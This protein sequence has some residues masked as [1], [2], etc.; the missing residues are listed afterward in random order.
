MLLSFIWTKLTC[1]RRLRSASVSVR[2]FQKARMRTIVRLSTLVGVKYHFPMKKN[3]YTGGGGV[4][5]LDINSIRFTVDSKSGSQSYL[6]HSSR[7]FRKST[8]VS[9]ES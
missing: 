4:R 3:N 8:E 1:G 5:T 6:T 9:P 2:I 7:R